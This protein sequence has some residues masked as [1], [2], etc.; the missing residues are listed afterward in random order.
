MIIALSGS[1]DIVV[2]DE[3]GLKTYTM[4]R[5]YIG[6]CVPALTWRHLENFSTN[7]IALTLASTVYDADDYVRNVQEFNELNNEG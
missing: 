7:S 3:S 2:E 6:L 4:N 1:F 5:S